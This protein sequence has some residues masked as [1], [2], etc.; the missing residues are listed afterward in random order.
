MNASIRTKLTATGAGALLVLGAF[1]APSLAKD[2]AGGG[3]TPPAE[4]GCYDVVSGDAGTLDRVIEETTTT[5]TTPRDG[6][7]VDLPLAGTPLEG[8]VVD[9]VDGFDDTPERTETTTTRTATD[10]VDFSLRVDLAADSCRDARYTITLTDETKAFVRAITIAGDGSTP[11][12]RFT[13]RFTLPANGAERCLFMNVTTADTQGQVADR[14]PDQADAFTVCTDGS[15][16]NLG[17]S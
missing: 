9:Y 10:E 11:S 6:G 14:A 5:T 16:G 12:V 3:G 2:K 8:T 1:A 17:W 13:D 4:A 15:G 7:T